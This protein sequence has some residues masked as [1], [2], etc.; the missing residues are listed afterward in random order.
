MGRM[1]RVTLKDFEDSFLIALHEPYKPFF[2]SHEKIPTYRSFMFTT[3]F[4]DLPKRSLS[5]KGEIK[6]N[7]KLFGTTPKRSRSSH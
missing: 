2:D 6:I 4:K 7:K 3:R 5:D 1:S